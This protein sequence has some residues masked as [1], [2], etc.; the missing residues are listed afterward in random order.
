MGCWLLALRKFAER[1]KRGKQDKILVSFGAH[2]SR[3]D[4][5]KFSRIIANH[6]GLFV[7]EAA[8][9]RTI[10]DAKARKRQLE[11][12]A[13]KGNWA[14]YISKRKG[15]QNNLVF[16]SE[17]IKLY[18]E[19]R[20]K[21]SYAEIMPR[22]ARIKMKSLEAREKELALKFSS[23]ILEGKIDSSLLVFNDYFEV[24]AGQHKLRNKAIS[25][26]LSR[27]KGN[28]VARYGT[29]HSTFF[30]DLKRLRP[31]ASRVFET[32]T[33]FSPFNSL[34]R[35]KV[36]GRAKPPSGRK[37]IGALID[38][39]AIPSGRIMESLEVSGNDPRIWLFSQ[40]LVSHPYEVLK[41]IVISHQKPKDV[42]SFKKNIFSGILSAS[43]LPENFMDLG[44]MQKFS[45]MKGLAERVAGKNSK[46][47]QLAYGFE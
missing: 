7:D 23:L 44:K 8:N 45:L 32:Q 4:V 37:L 14:D 20:G 16:E 43:G 18:R 30:R 5:K 22:T 38:L 1:A 47:Y 3:R 42:E 29:V 26:N 6:K 36:V 41:R 40:C 34:L 12:Y 10:G 25:R 35:E 46:I 9:V 24:L 39:I 27:M 13:K 33:I 31:E 19:K 28:V 21:I 11:Y 2:G 15:A 17:I